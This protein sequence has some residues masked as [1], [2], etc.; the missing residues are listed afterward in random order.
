MKTLKLLTTSINL[1]FLSIVFFSC[2][3]EKNIQ[4]EN[5]E[6]NNT[7][8]TVPFENIQIKKTVYN[9]NN[10]KDTI[11][12]YSSGSKIIIPKYAFLD[13]S[14]SP[15]KAVVNVT[16]REFSNALDVYLNGIPMDYD[17][18]GTEQVFETAG[19]IEIDAFSSGKRVFPNPENKISIEM[20]SFNNQADFN[21]YELDTLSKKWKNIGKDIISTS[22]YDIET[23]NLPKVPPEPKIAG[24]YAFSIGD[25]TGKYP[26]LNKYKNVMFEPVNNKFCGFSG[27]EIKVKESAGGIYEVIFIF[28]GYGNK[29]EESCKCY[30]AFKEGTDYNEAMKQYQKKY[31]SLINERNKKKQEL[32]E[33]W[34]NYFDVKK[35]Y[36]ELGLSDV[37]YKKGVS[38]LEGE[39]KIIRTFQINGF[40]IVNCDAPRS[41]PQGAELIASF[42]NKN[43]H[44]IQLNQIVLVEKG[45]NGIFRYK[46][47]VKF[48]PE[49]ENLLWGITSD[50]KLAYIKSEEMKAIKQTKGNYKFTMNIHPDKLTTYEDICKVLF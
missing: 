5:T 11:L 12:T 44:T 26:E 4:T 24:Q 21:L 3:E 16:Y 1:I 34:K 43:N 28:N 14:G 38:N 13:S 39:L 35:K 2:N 33:K 23:A 47:I 32:E 48:N 22:N 17:S 31:K 46:D 30:L 29:K 45:M 41:Y 50:N 9:I 10:D 25:N 7:R 27:T 19:M 49:R 42:Q 18:A 37:F 8:F 40:G 36:D 20:L 15:I 6:I